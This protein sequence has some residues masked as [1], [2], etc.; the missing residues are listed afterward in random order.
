MVSLLEPVHTSLV[1]ILSFRCGY[2][3]TLLGDISIS[4]ED[5]L[6]PFVYTL[7]KILRITAPRINP[8]G[9]RLVIH[10]HLTLSC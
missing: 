4:S 2:C 6:T 5:A 1:G 10:V 3:S 7:M 9:T 8:W